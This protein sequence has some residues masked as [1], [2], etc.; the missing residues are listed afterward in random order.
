MCI[1]LRIIKNGQIKFKEMENLKYT[2]GNWEYS[3]KEQVHEINEVN[4]MCNGGY[5]LCEGT[6]FKS[7]EETL[8]NV[9]LMAAAKDLLEAL[10]C[11]YLNCNNLTKEADDLIKS[12]IEKATK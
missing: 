8:A 9:K 5:I 7:K 11:A 12:A 6:S 4:I 10:K 2:K 3:V 1:Y